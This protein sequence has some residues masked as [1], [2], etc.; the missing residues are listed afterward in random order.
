MAWLTM[1]VSIYF[2]KY[3]HINKVVFSLKI[4]D[5]A[6]NWCFKPFLPFNVF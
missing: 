4:L 3:T 6:L 5:V 2:M 1:P